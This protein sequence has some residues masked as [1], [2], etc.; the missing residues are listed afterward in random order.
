MT[1]RPHS[2][3]RMTFRDGPGGEDFCEDCFRYGVAVLG[4]Q[5]QPDLTDIVESDFRQF[6]KEYS[7]SG[8][9][10]V[11]QG[12][13]CSFRYRMKAGD[14]IYAKSGNRIVG[15]GMVISRHRY[16]KSGKVLPRCLSGW[17][18]FRKVKWEKNFAAISSSEAPQMFDPSSF[19]TLLRL[20]GIRLHELLSAE[21]RTQKERDAQKGSTPKAQK[22]DVEEG[23]RQI[24]EI[25]FLSRNRAIIEERKR[26]F[27]EKCEVC[28]FSAE[29]AYG[30][31]ERDCLV[32]HH[33]MPLGGSAHARRTTLE[34]IVIVCPNCHQAMHS[35][36][37]PLTV[38]QLHEKLR[39]SW[40]QL[41]TS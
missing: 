40:E 28:G 3:W 29:I 20:D 25:A 24:K 1:V 39:F 27:G 18:Y 10:G 38:E 37:P 17:A 6:W 15:K 12:T 33:L 30:E 32:G 26:L 34:D 9:G 5:G 35:E 41:H 19:H 36:K 13:H 4:S 2:V 8:S 31:I 7:I 22:R 16:N 11:N 21:R 23:K 14:I